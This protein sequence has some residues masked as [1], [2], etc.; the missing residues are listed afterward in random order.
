VKAEKPESLVKPTAWQKAGGRALD[1]KC[2]RDGDEMIHNRSNGLL[3]RYGN[4][5]RR[6]I[7][8]ILILLAITSMPLMCDGEEKIVRVDP[9]GTLIYL[10]FHHKKE[11]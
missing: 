1:F 2:L 7:A 9:L 4:K 8:S 11:V 6:K 3:Y 10:I 5:S